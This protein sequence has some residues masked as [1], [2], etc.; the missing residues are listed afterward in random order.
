MTRVGVYGSLWILIVAVVAACGGGAPA[1][2]SSSSG[3]ASIAATPSPTP[4][5]LRACDPP[6]CTTPGFEIAVSLTLA[7]SGG[8]SG[9][10]NSVTFTL[11]RDA[12]QAVLVTGTIAPPWIQAT[13]AGNGASTVPFT[14]H[15]ARADVTGATTLTL[16]LHATDANNNQVDATVVVPVSAPSA[17]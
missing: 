11:R 10:V 1:Q 3:R 16:V 2:P 6:E 9:R 15:V 14:M 12:D 8:V 4:V 13:F 7:E 17:P 5:P